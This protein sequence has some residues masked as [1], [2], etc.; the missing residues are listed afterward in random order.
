MMKSE[1]TSLVEQL[2]DAFEA[3]CAAHN[4]EPNDT[5]KRHGYGHGGL[6]APW[7]VYTACAQLRAANEQLEALI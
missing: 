1:L 3:A 5:Y 7:P 6:R 2:A 4:Y